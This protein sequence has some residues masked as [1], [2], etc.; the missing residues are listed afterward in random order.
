MYVE[1]SKYSRTHFTYDKYKTEQ[2][3]NLHFLQNNPL[4]Q[5]YTS[6]SA[7]KYVEKISRR[8]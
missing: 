7:W 8:R 2:S 3:F 4:V 6:A 5:K 1:A